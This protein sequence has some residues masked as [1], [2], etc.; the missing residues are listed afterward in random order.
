[1][2]IYKL[3]ISEIYKLNLESFIEKCGFQ[4][5]SYEGEPAYKPGSVEGNYSSM[6]YVTANL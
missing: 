1:M 5:S 6:A 2:L 3:V 4:L